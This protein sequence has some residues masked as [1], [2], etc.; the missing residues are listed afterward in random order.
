MNNRK[1][2]QLTSKEF[3]GHA[4]LAESGCYEWTGSRQKW[5]GQLWFN[6]SNHLAHRTA[7]E[8]T[9]GPIPGRLHVLHH[10]DNGFC[11]RPS[12][13]FLGSHQDNMIDKEQKGRG[14]RPRG[15]SGGKTKLTETQ[16]LEIRALYNAG[17]IQTSLANEYGVSQVAISKIT[18]RETWVH[19]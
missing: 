9:S 18:R 8:L 7:W 13:L 3:F 10:C 15:R 14:N 4:K 16:V 12:H 19:V 1:T 5:Y 11:V 17:R 2:L 6:G